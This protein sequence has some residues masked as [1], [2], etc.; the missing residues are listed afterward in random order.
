MTGVHWGPLGYVVYKRTYSRKQ[1]SGQLEEWP[2]TCARVVNALAELGVDLNN[3]EQDTLYEYLLNF[4][5]CVSGRALWTLGTKTIERIGGDSLQSCWCVNVNSAKAF[6]FAFNQLMLGGGVGFN[7]QKKN[8]YELPVI[9]SP[10]IEHS[11]S[12]DVD[13]VVPDNREGWVELLGRVLDSYFNTEKDFTYSTLAIRPKGSPI[14]GFGGT[15]SG[16]ESLIHGI[17]QICKVLDSRR[18]RKL[19]P[20]DCLDIMNLIGSVVVAGNVRRSA[21]IALGD[22]EETYFLKAKRWDLSNVPNHRCMS[23]NS[24]VANCYEDLSDTFWESYD[25]GVGEPLGF[26]NLAAARNYGRMLDGPKPDGGVIGCNPCGEISLESYESCNLAEIFLPRVN[27]EE[28]KT[29]AY[30]MYK[31]TRLISGMTFQY[32]E[33]REVAQRNRRLGI[34]VSGFYESN[35]TAKDFDTV[36]RYV[37][38]LNSK[39][40]NPSI[41]L[42]TV[43]PSG[44][45]SLLP[46]V[47]PGAHPAYAPYYIRRVRM[48]TSHDLVDKCREHGYPVEP[49]LRFDGSI[50]P[51]TSVVSFPVDHS[52][53]TPA[54]D[55]TAVDMLETQKFLQKYWSDNS[56][57]MSVYYK[58]EELGEIKSWLK[59]NFQFIKGVSFLLRQEHGFAQAPYEEITKEH[60][61]E[62]NVTPLGGVTTSTLE[63]ESLLGADCDSG[64]CGVR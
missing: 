52:H 47:T 63:D 13:F 36:Y 39:Q 62:Y 2:D 27:A 60:Y 37:S 1:N 56:V 17:E 14:N 23:N 57:S 4:K 25:P 58:P 33:T 53:A 20:T 44:T 45:L 9:K 12:W 31:V 22:P 5:C 18:G 21:Q 41:K 40:A 43:K 19:N 59:D 49:Q 42:T 8:V 64:G 46:G 50:D 11:N 48:S 34:S 35:W 6:L 30:L 55:V 61:E 54:E 38:R 28:F 24:V 29:A 3:G 51:N 26:I 10:S 7:I 32:P 15:A 16:S